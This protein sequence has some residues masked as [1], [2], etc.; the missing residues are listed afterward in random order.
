MASLLI[1]GDLGLWNESGPC[2]SLIIENNTFQDCVYGGN[3]AQAVIQIGPEYESPDYIKEKY[4]RNIVI[5]NNVIKTFDASILWALSVDGLTFEGNQI[6][7]T[8]TYQPIFPDI[9]NL[10]IENC[11]QISI[12]GN[13]YRSL[14]GD[15]GTIKIDYK[16][17]N[18]QITENKGF[19]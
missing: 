4:S 1:T 17:T 7:Q 6:T 14:D 10:R 13:T 8:Q 2:D 11:N 9:P 12:M 16:S 15:T 3:G 5:R 18:I 19:N